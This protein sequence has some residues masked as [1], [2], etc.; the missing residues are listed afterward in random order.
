VNAGPAAAVFVGLAVWVAAAPPRAAVRLR[1]LAAPPEPSIATSA[2]RTLVTAV[3]DLRRG[4]H[5]IRERRAAV[6]ELCDGIGAELVAG[7]APDIALAHAAA[8][9]DEELRTALIAV[10]A[11]GDVAAQLDQVA[12]LPGAEGL[13]LLAGCWRIGAERGG[14]FAGVVEGL[15]AALRDEEAHRAEVAAQLA[16]PKATAR[17]LAALPLLGLAMAA[18]LGARPLAFLFG[19]LPGVACLFTGIGLDALGL[20]WTRRLAAAAEVPR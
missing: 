19:T 15:A 3:R 12:G 11:G 5:R 9:L 16:G 1:D 4:R 13:R 6:I 2:V 17:L 8:V 10:S 14:M 18:A 7:R 20:L